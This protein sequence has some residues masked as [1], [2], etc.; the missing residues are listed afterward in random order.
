MKTP[1]IVISY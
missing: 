1:G